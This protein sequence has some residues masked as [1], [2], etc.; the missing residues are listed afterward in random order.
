MHILYKIVQTHVTV[1]NIK[2]D[3]I[4]I[5]IIKKTS[6]KFYNSVSLTCATKTIG[7]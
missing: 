2:N 4:K 6:T 1:K 3:E 5:V 7:K